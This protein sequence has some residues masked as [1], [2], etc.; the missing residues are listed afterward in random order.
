[1]ETH[2]INGKQ[3]IGIKATQPIAMMTLQIHNSW[4]A[5]KHHLMVKN[6]PRKNIES[7]KD[8]PLETY[9]RKGIN[10]NSYHLSM[11]RQI[12]WGRNSR[13]LIIWRHLSL[14]EWYQGFPVC[15]L[16]SLISWRSSFH[17]CKIS[18]FLDLTIRTITRIKHNFSKKEINLII[19]VMR[20]TITLT[21][22]RKIQTLETFDFKWRNWSYFERTIIL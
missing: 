14:V 22:P 12:N 9:K 17:L 5:K 13:N 1:M 2:K 10:K 16:V 18:T 4:S 21:L 19:I 3:T 6:N 20:I 8:I 15:F 7:R 11:R